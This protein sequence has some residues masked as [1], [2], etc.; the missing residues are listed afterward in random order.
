LVPGYQEDILNLDNPITDITWTPDPAFI[1]NDVTV[2]AVITYTNDI[3]SATLSWALASTSYYTDVAMDDQGDDIFT[4]V[5]PAMA[6][7]DD[8]FLVR[9]TA[10]TADGQTLH[11][12]IVTIPV[13]TGSPL[14]APSPSV[15]RPW[16]T[17]PMWTTPSWTRTWTSW[18]HPRPRRYGSLSHRLV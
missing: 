11:S 13:Y 1:G 10:R 2:S 12:S 8:D 3:T 6:D 4:G 9:I 7:I 16:A 15:P 5:I 14:L 18:H 17:T